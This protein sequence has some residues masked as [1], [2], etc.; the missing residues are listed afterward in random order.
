MK[1]IIGVVGGGP[2]GILT[3]AQACLQG[4]VSKVLW[5]DDGNFQG[6]TLKFYPS[7]P[8]NTKLDHLDCNVQFFS[9]NPIGRFK[10]TH[11]QVKT[12]VKTVRS[13]AITIDAAD[14]LQSIDPSS[15]GFPRMKDMNHLF[16][17]LSNALG[18]EEKIIKVP[19]EVKQVL[20][21]SNG[22]WKLDGENIEMDALVF[23]TGTPSPK[24][25]KGICKNKVI[26]PTIALSRPKLAL[27]F[28]N[29]WNKKIAILGN[30]H[31]SVLALRNIFSILGNR[32][33][34]ESVSIFKRRE[35]RY[36]EWKN[37]AYKYN[38]TGLKGIAAAF[39]LGEGKKVLEQNS[40]FIDDFNEDD[41][42]VIIPLIGFER[43]A[44]KLPS[45][46]LSQ[47]FVVGESLPVSCSVEDLVYNQENASITLAN[48]DNIGLYEVGS[49]RPE[50][51]I[52]ND[53]SGVPEVCY[54]KFGTE[55]KRDGW[56]R[57][58]IVGW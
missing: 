28:A 1:K 47:D 32:K 11:S 14:E 12:A 23:A 52:D 13:N 57:E 25:F 30:S 26:D 53:L 8:S 55:T 31:S 48:G 36:A 2:A 19:Q 33:A 37:N 22:K 49:S 56:I 39:A 58:H 4:A 51:Y 50:F 40:Y 42:D 54:E 24:A 10:R 15:Y 9:K 35:V 34:E 46:T 43:D 44:A 27:H 6:G 41:F 21:L 16:F 18:E 17:T 45:L 38:S 7:I 3:S 5:F 29:Q 20:Q